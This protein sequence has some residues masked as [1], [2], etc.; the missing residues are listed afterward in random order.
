MPY[1]VLFNGEDLEVVNKLTDILTVKKT[2]LSYIQGGPIKTE[3][4]LTV[5]IFAMVCGRKACDVLS[6][7]IFSLEISTKRAFRTI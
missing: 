2:S 5:D 4:F 7:Q 6:L 3:L 1:G